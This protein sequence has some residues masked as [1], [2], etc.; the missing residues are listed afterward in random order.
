MLLGWH[1]P[2]QTLGTKSIL[3]F[4]TIGRECYQRKGIY[5]G[6]PL[7]SA[8]AFGSPKHARRGPTRAPA[9]SE[10]PPYIATCL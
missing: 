2:R 1:G 6:C 8:P 7:I 4:T 3:V 10:G 9:A 5:S